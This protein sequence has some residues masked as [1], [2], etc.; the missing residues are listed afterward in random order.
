[1]RI[2][3]MGT[4]EFAVPSL[5]ALSEAGH[6]LAG[7]F[8]Q[9]DKPRGRGMRT[10]Y[11]P[12]KECALRLGIPV[13]QPE[14][15]KNRGQE[16]LLR[17][18]APELI[19]VV[20]YG[21][22]LPSYVLDCPPCGAVNVH[23]SLLPKYRGAGPVQWAV[24]NGEEKTGVTTM[25]MAKEID[26][27]DM[28]LK[29]ETPVGPEETA[30]EV[31]DRL[32]HL[33]AALLC[34]TVSQIARGSAPRIPQEHTQATY[35]PMLKKEDACIDWKKPAAQILNL[36]RGTFPWPGAYTQTGGGALKLYVLSDTG[37]QTA[38]AAGTVVGCGPGG[39]RVACG[40]GQ[41]VL[42]SEVQAQGGRRMASADYFRGHA[43][44]AGF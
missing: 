18:L 12:V 2:V 10:G 39:L 33:G 25:Y 32:M 38:S 35:A 27:G 41:V 28:I 40:D 1:M 42:V 31:H 3:F 44:P 34:E 22:L 15:F 30:Q 8:T 6:T 23:G 17:E 29:A 16:A 14:T 21:K 37:E 26:T 20:A 19:A 9:P 36:A 24:I 4:P 13:F 5:Q 11:S 43:I 7:V